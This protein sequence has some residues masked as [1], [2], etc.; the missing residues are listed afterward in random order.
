MCKIKYP[1][2]AG[3]TTMALL[4]QPVAGADWQEE[5]ET[6]TSQVLPQAIANRHWFHARPELGNRE[7][8]TARKIIDE[9]NRLGF[10][11]IE[12]GVAHTGV[13]AVLKGGLSGPTV[14]LRAD[15]DGLPVTEKTGLAFASKVT[16]LWQGVETGVMHA[17]GHDAH[18]A[19]LLG[20]AEV[21]SQMREGIPGNVKFI[22]Q[23]A[24]EG[25]PVGEEGG[26]Q[27]MI[28]Q[29][30]LGGRYAPGAI[31]GLHVFPGRT[32]SIMYKADGFM[33]AADS[34]EIEIVGKQAHG[35]MPWGGVDP[36]TAAAQ[37][38]NALQTVVS[39]QLD[40]S[41]APAVVTIGSIHGGNRGNIIPERV[42]LTG[43]IRTL[44][45]G[46]REQVQAL[47]KQT[48]QQAAM[49]MGAKALVSID[50]GYPV[51]F[52][53][54]KLTKAMRPVLERTALGGLATEVKPY[55]GAEDFSFYANEIPGLFFALGVAHDD[56]TVEIATNH[57]PYFYVNDKALP[58][59]IKALSQL[60]LEWL[61][62]N[63]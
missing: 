60:A 7:F 12:Q 28:K 5:V 35:S 33:A 1:L 50:L 47:I 59:G 3:L 15:M 24:E 20:V 8:E 4:L 17:C 45:P 46:M 23:P 63:R 43:T 2:L 30:V 9:L 57:S 29:G 10:D 48:A 37:V 14:A 55:M 18:M 54:A 32:G 11:E 22:F 58:V 34:L 27:L 19:I 16:T 26:A 38:I 41:Q 56:P 61:Y 62:S 21:L 36:I 40:I 52:N 25:P 44:D 53:D 51:T 31:F 13:V 6:L 49:S 42:K 39:R